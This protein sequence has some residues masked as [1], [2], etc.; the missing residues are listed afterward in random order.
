MRARLGDPAANGRR[1]EFSRGTTVCG[2]IR[3]AELDRIR[4]R[5][6]RTISA[7]PC[8]HPTR[9]C[10]VA[11]C[12]CTRSFT[13]ASRLARLRLD[14]LPSIGCRERLSKMR[15]SS[16]SALSPASAALFLLQALPPV[17]AAYSLQA[18]WQGE[19]FFDGWDFWGNRDNLT[20]GAPTTSPTPMRDRTKSAD[21]IWFLQ[22][23]CTMSVAMRQREGASHIPTRPATSS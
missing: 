9:S 8:N 3:R 1:G 17:E 23:R 11:L 4:T 22:A 19:S 13:A 18:L 7:P 14:T 6:R 20:N 15:W 2:W 16:T 12:L 21:L 5:R 10:I